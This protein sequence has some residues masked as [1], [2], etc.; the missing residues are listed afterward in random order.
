MSF[1]SNSGKNKEKRKSILCNLFYCM[2]NFGKFWTRNKPFVLSGLTGLAYH[3]SMPAAM[4]GC[5]FNLQREFIQ[6]V[7]S[8][9]L[10]IKGKALLAQGRKSSNVHERKVP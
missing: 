4:V 9:N 7:F 3:I 2:F 5:L 1:S 10:L 8:V 6:W